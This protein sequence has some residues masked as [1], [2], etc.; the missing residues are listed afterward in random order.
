MFTPGNE[1]Q[2][3]KAR[4]GCACL[5][6]SCMSRRELNDGAFASAF[7]WHAAVVEAEAWTLNISRAC[8][9]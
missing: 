6:P 9:Q 1:Q 4:Y 2:A 8:L 7:H 5:L 3:P